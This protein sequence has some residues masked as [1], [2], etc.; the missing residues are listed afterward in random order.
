[1]SL[2]PYIDRKTIHERLKAVFPEGVPQRTYCVREAA[3]STVFTMLYMGAIEGSGEWAA[4][5]QIVRMTDSQ[6]AL[7]TDHDRTSYASKSMQPGFHPQG[8]TWYLENSREQIRDETIRQGLI[9]N[10]AAIERPGLPTTSSKPRYALTSAFASLFDPALS[11][12]DFAKAAEHWR[13]QHLSATRWQERFYCGAA[14]SRRARA[15]SLPFQTARH[16]GW[17]RDPVR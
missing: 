1:V 9:P 6:A 13:Q 11:G 16:D 3:A 8:K 2:A 5:K 12:E 15:F 14:P 10:N 17:R 7:T 4:P